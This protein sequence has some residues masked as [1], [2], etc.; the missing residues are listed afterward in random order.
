MSR[1]VAAL[2][3]TGVGFYIGG[4]IVMGTVGG[5]WLDNKLDTKPVFLLIGLVLGVIVAVFGVY[6]MLRPLLGNQ[7]D[8][9]N[10]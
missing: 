5:L 1:W 4:C 8:K 10:D 3:L 2:R 9:E 6:Q 7:Q